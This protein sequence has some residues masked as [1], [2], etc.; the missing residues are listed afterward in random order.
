MAIKDTIGQ[1]NNDTISQKHV[2]ST[3]EPLLNDS[4]DYENLWTKDKEFWSQQV[5][6]NVFLPLKRKTSALQARIFGPKMSAKE[7]FHCSTKVS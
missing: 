2:L 6:L 4:L 7:R 3:V 1:S 5:Q